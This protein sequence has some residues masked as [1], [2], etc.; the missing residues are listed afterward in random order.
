M[1]GEDLVKASEILKRGEL[2]AIPTETVYGLA[3]NALDPNAVA[4]IYEAKERPSF[5]PLI[6]HVASI[7]EAKK[8][9]K[10]FP[11]I[12][13]Q[14]AEAFWP[15]SISLLLPK[16]SII[17]DLTTAGLPN[18]VI[19]I[20]NHPLTLELLKSLDFP[21]AAPSANISNT[22]SPTTAEHVQLGLGSKIEYILD[23]GKS[24]IGLESTI[25][26]I[27]QDKV[28]ILREG[29]VSR[30]DIL[31]KTGIKVG[32]SNGNQIQSPGNLK[33]HY[34][35]TKPLF[36]VQDITEYI[37]SNPNGRY[38]ALLFEEKNVQCQSLLLSKTYTMSEIANNLFD[39]M[40]RA[41]ND[42][43]DYILIEPIQEIGIGR[44]I[45]DRIARAAS[46]I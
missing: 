3:A 13:E 22:V 37:N 23:G 12:A 9:V 10:E 4:K 17:P 14:I 26:A 11:E 25:L 7:K 28:V 39:F 45:A 32:A 5:N 36:I 46:E 6:V 21:L 44:A 35:T 24:A 34:S 31:A 33:R 1:I 30:E 42:N 8:Y 29:G 16:H 2:V 40:R 20:P 19:R 27:E 38:S 15:G 18:V 43:S 41:D